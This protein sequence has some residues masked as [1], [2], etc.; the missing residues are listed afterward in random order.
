MLYFRA[1]QISNHCV[2]SP[3]VQG[4]DVVLDARDTSKHCH[5]SQYNTYVLDKLTFAGSHRDA[6]NRGA[7]V[8]LNP[9][10]L[11][12]GAMHRNFLTIGVS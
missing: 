1:A 11:E 8:R 7:G 10:F 9:T 6:P 3:A 12:E 4:E 5:V 2:S